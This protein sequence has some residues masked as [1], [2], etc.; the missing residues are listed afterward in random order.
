MIRRV[1]KIDKALTVTLESQ[2]RAEF[3]WYTNV[4][5]IHRTNMESKLSLADKQQNIQSSSSHGKR[6]SGRVQ[7]CRVG[8]TEQAHL[9]LDPNNDPTQCQSDSDDDILDA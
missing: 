6:G 5:C 2:C 9:L 8:T 1:G 7:Y 3:E 4:T